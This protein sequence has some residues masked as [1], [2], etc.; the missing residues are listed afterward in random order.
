[1]AYATRKQAR[2]LLVTA[3]ESVSGTWLTYTN[4]FEKGKGLPSINVVYNGIVNGIDSYDARAIGYKFNIYVLYD[5][6]SDT[7]EEIG[8][9]FDDALDSAE[10]IVEIKNKEILE[11]IHHMIY[12]LGDSNSIKDYTNGNNRIIG[13][14]TEVQMEANR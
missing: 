14:V 12:T 10:D 4:I 5:L 7:N 2:D 8:T 11:S 13:L 3:I 6:N 9:V 1:M